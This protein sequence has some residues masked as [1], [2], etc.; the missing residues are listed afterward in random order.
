MVDNDTVRLIDLI[1]YKFE[2]E[3]TIIISKDG[4]KTFDKIFRQME[5]AF[6]I[7]SRDTLKDIPQKSM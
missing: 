1:H 3:I 5:D 6:I 4:P 2:D 7:M